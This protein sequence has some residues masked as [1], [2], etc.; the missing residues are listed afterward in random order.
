MDQTY[1]FLPLLHCKRI[2]DIRLGF[3]I[4]MGLWIFSGTAYAQ[5]ENPEDILKKVGDDIYML[6]EMKI[7]VSKGHIEIP[8]KINMSEGLIEVILCRKEGKVHESLLVTDVSPLE[9]QTALLLLGLDPVNEVP[10]I[11][12]E[13]DPVSQFRSI[14]TSGDSVRLYISHTV[15]GE[16]VKKP[17]EHFVYDESVDQTLEPSTWL[18]RGAA[19]HQNGHVLV[20]PDV[21]MIATYH[22]PVA[23]MELNSQS[24]FNDELFYINKDAKLTIGKKVKLI[25]EKR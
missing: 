19:T 3:L 16:T 6:K 1:K 5:Q 7:D 21:T 9:F 10:D 18:F 15:N 13:V 2:S 25:I 12:S 17:V 23:M 24:K 11:A 8:G 22:D 4:I 14:E 20:D